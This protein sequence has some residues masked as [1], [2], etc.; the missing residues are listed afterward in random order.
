M[1]DNP[2]E[3]AE[4]LRMIEALL[5]AAI[6]PLDEATVLALAPVGL[7]AE[8]DRFIEAVAE[9]QPSRLVPLLRRLRAG[10]TTP[11]GLLLALQRHFRT[12][13]L[14]AVH[15]GGPDAGIAR[16]RPPLWGKRRDAFVRQLRKWRSNRLEQACRLLFEADSRV[17]SSGAAPDFALVERCALRLAIIA[18]R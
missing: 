17:R 6:E 1:S 18:Q 14:A 10:G 3:Q 8:V 13:L 15:A 12:L 5:F 7:D 11:V 16:V 4:Y 2:Q 9:G